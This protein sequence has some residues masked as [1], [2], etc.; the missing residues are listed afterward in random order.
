[1]SPE[2]KIE[3]DKIHILNIRTLK[4]NIDASAE[5]NTEKIAGHQF[6]FELNTGLNPAEKVVG[7]QL[8]VNINAVDKDDKPLNI[9]GSYTHEMLFH[10][11]NLDEFIESK[12]GSNVIDAGMGSTLISIIYSTVRGIICTRTQGTSLG[13]VVLPVIDPKKLMGVIGKEEMKAE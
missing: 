1:M 13:L 4:G 9:K 2:R 10:V 6:S 11:D 3:A 5:A 8:L 7:L 12:D